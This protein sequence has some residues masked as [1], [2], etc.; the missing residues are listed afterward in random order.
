MYVLSIFS[1]SCR[2]YVIKLYIVS[3]LMIYVNT[4]LFTD[5][6]LLITLK[7]LYNLWQFCNSWRFALCQCIQHIS[8]WHIIQSHLFQGS[9]HLL[10]NCIWLRTLFSCRIKK[11]EQSVSEIWGA[12]LINHD[13]IG[14]VFCAWNGNVLHIKSQDWSNFTAYNC[15]LLSIP[16]CFLFKAI[17][18]FPRQLQ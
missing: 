16:I 14:P 3:S 18:H 8:Q 7:T 2:V 15:R 6:L 4:Y 11:L 12:Y 9:L 13:R 5:C 10:S 17:L 1:S